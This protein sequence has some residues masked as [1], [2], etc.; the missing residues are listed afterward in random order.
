[1]QWCSDPQVHTILHQ[2]IRLFSAFLLILPPLPSLGPSLSFKPSPFSRALPPLS[3]SPPSP[4]SLLPL[5]GFLPSP[6]ALPG[7]SQHLPPL[8]VTPPSPRCLSPLLGCPTV[9]GPPPAPR[10]PSPAASPGPCRGRARS[11]AGS[12]RGRRGRVSSAPRRSRDTAPAAA[13]RRRSGPGCARAVPGQGLRDVG[14]RR[15]SLRTVRAPSAARFVPSRLAD[16]LQR[17]WSARG[18]PVAPCPQLSR[19]MVLSASERDVCASRR[20]SVCVRVYLSVCL[21]LCVGA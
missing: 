4:R 20:G 2:R 12:G 9:P 19:K 8:P 5:P 3:A 17:S 13:P 15:G 21:C 10:S 1:M 6:R 14:A 7:L 16:A 11:T 18:I